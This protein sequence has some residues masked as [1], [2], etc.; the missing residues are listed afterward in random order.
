[1]SYLRHDE[2]YALDSTVVKIHPDVHGARKNGA[3]AIGKTSGGWNTKIHALA[4]GDTRTTAFS[5]SAGN[6]S[7]CT[8]R[9]AVA[10]NGWAAGTDRPAAGVPGLW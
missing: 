5:L 6:V 3:Q 8:G 10:G 2:V 1:M 4:M 7:R 9:A